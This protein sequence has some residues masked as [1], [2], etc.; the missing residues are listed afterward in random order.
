MTAAAEDAA[1]IHTEPVRPRR[2]R[3]TRTDWLCIGLVVFHVTL[4]TVSSFTTAYLLARP[5]LHLALVGS[6]SALVSG[7]VFV[8]VGELPLALVVL[9]GCSGRGLRRRL[10]VGRSSLR[11]PV[12]DDLVK[13]AGVP[14]RRVDQAERL[15]GRHGLWILAIRFF[16]PVPNI[17]LQMLAGAGGMSLR[18]YLAGSLLGGLLWV[19]PL[20]ALGF[21]IGHPAIAVIDVITRNALKV[22][23]AI[24][25]SR[26]CGRR[27]RRSEPARQPSRGAEALTAAS[28]SRAG[29]QGCH[30]RS[31]RTA[32]TRS[33]SLGWCT[34]E[35]SRAMRARAIS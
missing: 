33:A 30:S 5:V 26:W 27:S 4:R 35:R 3:G 13:Y 18:R 1:P 2:L 19:G 34:S 10:L 22:T 8:R 16:Q 11:A 25:G 32:S 6:I 20:V 21:A 17:A 7:G 28:A 24:V 14:A 9:T 31:H 23:I 15:M 29:Q 12:R